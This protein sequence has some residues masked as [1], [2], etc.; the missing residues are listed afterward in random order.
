MTA[1]ILDGKKI[2]AEIRASVKGETLLLKERGIVPGLAVVLVGDNPASKVYVGQK[3]KGC[4]EAGFAS[5]LHRLPGGTSQKDLLD[6]IG[7]LNADPLVH[8]I[9]VQ[10]PLPDQIDEEKVIAAIKPEKDVDGFSPVNMGRLVAGMSA[11]EPCTPK[12]IMRLLEASGIELAGKEAVVIGRSNIVGKPVAL[13]LLARSATVTVCHSRTKDLAEHTK[14][15]D[16]L[17]AAVGRPR[18]VTADMVKDGV[19]VIDVG[20]NRL[21]EG[22]VGDVD[23]EGVSEKA[24]WITPVPG[25]VGPMTIAMLLE[26]TLEQA[27]LSGEGRS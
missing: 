8:G 5:F 16:I 24:S 1:K 3:E 11:I 20:I 12:G 10:L 2:A 27:K 23:F 25:G 7:K 19:V 18:F 22:L 21:E 13:M 26:N 4:L 6:L 17:V 15:A 9:L 14:R